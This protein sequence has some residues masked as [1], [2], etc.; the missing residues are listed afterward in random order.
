MR[1]FWQRVFAK[2]CINIKFLKCF[3]LNRSA[4]PSDP[5]FPY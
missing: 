4:Q 2:C 5:Y 1:W 3:Q